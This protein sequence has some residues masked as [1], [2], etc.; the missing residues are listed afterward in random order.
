VDAQ[1]DLRE[2]T[3][4]KLTA[5]PIEANLPANCQVTLQLLV[6]CKIKQCLFIGG[7]AYVLPIAASSEH[8]WIPL[9]FYAHCIPCKQHAKLSDDM[10]DRWFISY[11]SQWLDWYNNS[12]SDT[13]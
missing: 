3:A 2:V 4:A 12:Q 13:V 9:Q 11:S 5:D 7:Y 10:I 1:F 8:R 6:M